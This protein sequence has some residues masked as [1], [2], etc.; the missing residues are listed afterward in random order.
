MTE[1]RR[2]EEKEEEEDDKEEEW[3]KRRRSSSRKGRR[4]RSLFVSSDTA[5]G[6]RA[7]ADERGRFAP[8]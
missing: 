7:P 1:W 6:P 2:G 8:A 3:R 4:H 5:V